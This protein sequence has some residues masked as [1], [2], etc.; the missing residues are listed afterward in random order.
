MK[1]VLDGADDR[2]EDDDHDRRQKAECE[3]EE[4]LHGYLRGLLART[5]TPLVTHLIGLSLQNPT[6][7][8]AKGVGLRKHHRKRDQV[9][10]VGPQ[11]Q[12]LQGVM[13]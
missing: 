2:S 5:L 11:L 8:E 12:V 10:D 13:S 7:R 4:N 3:R 6:D 9:V 1:G